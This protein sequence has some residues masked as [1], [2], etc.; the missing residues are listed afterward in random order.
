MEKFGHVDIP[1]NVVGGYLGGK[2]VAGLDMKEWDT[3][4]NKK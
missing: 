1:I 4:M 3:M 2:S